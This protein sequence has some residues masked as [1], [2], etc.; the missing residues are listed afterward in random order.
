MMKMK[1][2][3]MKMDALFQLEN[4]NINTIYL[5]S[6]WFCRNTTFHLVIK[7]YAIILIIILPIIILLIT[8]II[9]GLEFRVRDSIHRFGDCKWMIVDDHG[10][11]HN[12]II[13]VQVQMCQV[14]SVIAGCFSL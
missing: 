14:L 10:S 13:E 7:N 5:V 8:A 11:M 6:Y 2:L 3:V 4:T 9:E 1:K 12:N